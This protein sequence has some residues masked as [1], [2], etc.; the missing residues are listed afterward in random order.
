MSFL[1]R[2]VWQIG[3]HRIQDPVDENP[4]VSGRSLIA[5]IVLIEV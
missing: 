4:E 1:E 3:P 2:W 5:K